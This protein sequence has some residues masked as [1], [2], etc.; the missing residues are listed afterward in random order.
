MLLKSLSYNEFYPYLFIALE[1]GKEFILNVTSSCPVSLLLYQH[2]W[3]EGKGRFFFFLRERFNLWHPS[4]PND[5]SS[6]LD[7]DTNNFLV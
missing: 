2:L 1:V 5:N 3:F 4:V 6:S 7:Q